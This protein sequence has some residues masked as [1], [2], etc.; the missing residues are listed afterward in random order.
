[1]TRYSPWAGGENRSIV[2][3]VGGPEPGQPAAGQVATAPGVMAISSSI[4]GTAKTGPRRR[5]T[6][7]RERAVESA[8]QQSPRQGEQVPGQAPRI[9]VSR[10]GRHGSGSR[11]PG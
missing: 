6:P 11:Q 9:V 1:M 3:R 7:R 8:H 4:V 10:P 2:A 5:E